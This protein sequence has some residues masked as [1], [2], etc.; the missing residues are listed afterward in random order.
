MQYF[1]AGQ[2][3]LSKP[4]FRI[5]ELLTPKAGEGTWNPQKFWST[6]QNRK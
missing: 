2:V 4:C 5:G 3:T 1:W 6:W